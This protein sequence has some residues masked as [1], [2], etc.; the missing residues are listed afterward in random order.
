MRWKR[1]VLKLEEEFDD[2]DDGHDR[3]LFQSRF[4][5][6]DGIAQLQSTLEHLNLRQQFLDVFGLPAP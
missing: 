6:V 2:D 5:E 3:L 4:Y 1:L